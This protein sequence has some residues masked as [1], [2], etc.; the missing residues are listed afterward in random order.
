MIAAVALLAAFICPGDQKL[1]LDLKE[2][3]AALL[4]AEPGSD[5]QKYAVRALRFQS[6]P[7]DAGP[8]ADCADKPVIEG[9]DVFEANLTGEKDKL[10]QVRARACKGDKE[11]ET[12]SLRIADLVPL[13][14]GQ[15]CK[16]EGADLSVDQRASD[17]PCENP[18]K[19]PRTL[20]LVEL[21]QKGRKVVQTRDQA[22]S[23]DDPGG[24]TSSVKTV[25]YEA[26][27]WQLKK[28]FESPLYDST[29]QAQGRQLVASWKLSFGKTVPKEISVQRCVEG[30]SK[31][32]EPDVFVYSKP[33]GKYVPR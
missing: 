31:C 6:I 27:G 25:I 22:G 1:R 29:T 16:L 15:L 21:T 12:Q 30:A 18:G 7:G 9:V 11:N 20:S 19:L 5:E 14:E 24:R 28:I 17:R 3:K 23:C 4:K 13:A 33:G 26:Q 8:E 32:E 10:V 2:W